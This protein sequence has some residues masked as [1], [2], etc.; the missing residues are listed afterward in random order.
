MTAG[1]ELFSVV[2][3]DVDEAVLV[4]LSEMARETV[5]EDGSHATR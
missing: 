2:K 4:R 5:G 1:K 3:P